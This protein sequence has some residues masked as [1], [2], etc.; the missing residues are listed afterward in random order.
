MGL[1]GEGPL[2]EVKTKAPNSDF[3]KNSSSVAARQA[4]VRG[5]TSSAQ[6]G[7]MSSTATRRL[8]RAY[9]HRAQEVQRG[10]DVGLRDGCVLRDAGARELHL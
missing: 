5:A 8:Q 2:G 9:C 6:R 4:E 10:P 7:S 3:L 1:S